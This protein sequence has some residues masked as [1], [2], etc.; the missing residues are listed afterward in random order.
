MPGWL[1]IGCTER[2]VAER[3]R[4]LSGATGVREPFEIVHVFEVPSG[5]AEEA[6]RIAHS[7]LSHV[8]RRKEFFCC[9]REEAVSSIGTALK[10]L[11]SSGIDVVAKRDAIRELWTREKALRN[12]AA[13]RYHEYRLA[14]QRVEDEYTSALRLVE[15]ETSRRCAGQLLFNRIVFGSIV[16]A[17]TTLVGI[18][19][20]G[21]AALLT[22][23]PFGAVWMTLLSLAIPIGVSELPAYK[24]QA[25]SAQ[26]K[27][28]EQLRHCECDRE[29]QGREVTQITENI[30]VERH[31]QEEE[32]KS[33]GV[34][35]L[36]ASGGR[37][38]RRH[39]K[40]RH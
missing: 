7:A 1:K 10:P 22:V 9:K 24:R 38:K 20:G 8:R 6:E 37:K 33:V 18:Q 16:A 17:V 30:R 3:C 19:W 27:R 12:Q 11:M 26:Q 35:P 14:V 5:M 32:M 21:V 4:E 25:A 13:A 15:E 28:Q 36:F 2:S 29:A 39:W 31:R 40:R 34:S 23:V